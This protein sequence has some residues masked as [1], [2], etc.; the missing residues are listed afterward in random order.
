VVANDDS[1]K[2]STLLA[3]EIQ[4]DDEQPRANDSPTQEQLEA[5]FDKSVETSLIEEDKAAMAGWK[6]MQMEEGG[7][8]GELHNKDKQCSMIAW[9]LAM[10]VHIPSLEQFPALMNKI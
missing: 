9:I 1:S 5:S 10:V 6:R 7:D 3:G 2:D 4:Y 8:H